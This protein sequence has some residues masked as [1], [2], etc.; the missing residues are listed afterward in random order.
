MKSIE[1]AMK[2]K[3]CNVCLSL[4]GFQGGVRGSISILDFMLKALES[5]QIDF[6]VSY[7]LNR[8]AKPLKGCDFVVVEMV[9]QM[10]GEKLAGRARVALSSGSMAIAAN[11][12]RKV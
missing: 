1:K 11:A 2:G 7:S 10:L 3:D 5:G 6:G 4:D 12:N 9:P 8:F